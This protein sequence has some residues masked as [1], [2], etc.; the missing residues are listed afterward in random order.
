MIK[1]AILLPLDP[2]QV[3]F[4]KVVFVLQLEIVQD[5][6]IKNK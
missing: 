3:K 6:T 5:N 4:Y 2:M 1:L